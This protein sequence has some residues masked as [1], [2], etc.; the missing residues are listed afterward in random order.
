MVR[1][2]CPACGRP[3]LADLPAGVLRSSF[4][5]RLHAVIAL[6]AG[7]MRCS[8]ELIARHVSLV[9]GIEISAGAVD[10]AIRRVSLVLHDPWRELDQAI[11]R[12]KVVHADETTWLMKADPQLLWVAA[13]TAIVCYR[14][15]P[16]RTQEAAKK[17]LGEDFG[18]FVV[19][20]LCRVGGRRHAPH[21]EAD[22]RWFPPA[23]LS[24]GRWVLPSPAA[25]ERLSAAAFPR[26]QRR[27]AHRPALVSPLDA[28]LACRLR[29]RCGTWP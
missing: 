4:G 19:S 12:A 13:S 23:P 25:S 1:L 9:L 2:Q 15:D 3:A 29:R 17:L 27:R 14:V 24:T 5:I 26:A 7:G 11:K 6:L 20:G 28:V 16:R 10:A 21:G 18:G 22:W 8:R